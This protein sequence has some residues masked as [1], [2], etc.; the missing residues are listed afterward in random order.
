MAAA[1][2]E[3]IHGETLQLL[4]IFDDSVKP[5]ATIITQEIMISEERFTDHK[6]LHEL[7]IRSSLQLMYAAQPWLPVLTKPQ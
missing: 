6:A 5:L 2:I 3:N 7:M 1:I 4:A